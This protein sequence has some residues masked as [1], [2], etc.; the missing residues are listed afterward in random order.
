MQWPAEPQAFRYSRRME[1]TQPSGRSFG[2][3]PLLITNDCSLATS[4]LKGGQKPAKRLL[5]GSTWFAFHAPRLWARVFSIA[6]R[7]LGLSA[8]LALRIPASMV[9]SQSR[10]GM[11]EFLAAS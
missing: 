6:G 3:S 7:G 5:Y 8:D 2:I 11:A 4:T 10:C 1:W 9:C